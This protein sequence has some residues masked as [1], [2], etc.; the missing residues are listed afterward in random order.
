[1][2]GMARKR[3]R[4]RKYEPDMLG[5]LKHKKVRITAKMTLTD[6]VR[7]EKGQKVDATIRG[8]PIRMRRK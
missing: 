4:P 3:G 5:S 7:L 1:M 2:G 6:L 8:I